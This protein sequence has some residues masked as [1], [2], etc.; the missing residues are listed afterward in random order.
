M[1]WRL[2]FAAISILAGFSVIG[3]I[4]HR[5]G[6]DLPP[7]SEKKESGAVA[8]DPS[9]PGPLSLQELR[10]EVLN[11]KRPSQGLPLDP[12]ESQGEGAYELS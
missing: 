10:N 3:V 12:G 5:T 11:G 9:F 6:T 1:R 2:F 7:A 4:A 8:M